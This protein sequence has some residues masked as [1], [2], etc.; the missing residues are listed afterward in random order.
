MPASAA[1]PIGPFRGCPRY[2]C[3]GRRAD[4]RRE[5][6]HPTK[7]AQQAPMRFPQFEDALSIDSD[8]HLDAGAP[9]ARIGHSVEMAK[10][11]KQGADAAHDIARDTG[12]RL[13]AV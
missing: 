9:L 10:R 12:E 13:Q 2:R 3:T 6:R 7:A 8:P 1:Q 4:G 5:A 11:L